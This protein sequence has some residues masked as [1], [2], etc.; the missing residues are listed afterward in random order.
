MIKKDKNK[1]AFGEKNT[2]A[3]KEEMERKFAPR[4]KALQMKDEFQAQEEK[5][6]KKKRK[7]LNLRLEE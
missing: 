7:T 5:R 3:I 6:K 4:M 2:K 1:S